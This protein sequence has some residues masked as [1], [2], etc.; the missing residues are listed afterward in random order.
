MHSRLRI[1]RTLLIL[2]LGIAA[3]GRT[4]A[5][6]APHLVAPPA[7]DPRHQT[8]RYRVAGVSTREQRSAIVATGAAIESVGPSEVIVVATPEQAH[9][10]AALGL[11]LEPSPRPSD[12]PIVDAAYHTY[13]EMVADIQAVAAAHPAIVRLFSIGQSYEG[14]ELWAAK[15]SANVDRDEDEPEALF[16]GLYHAREHLT[17]EMLLY[18]LHLLAD[19]YGLAGQEQITDLVDTREIYLIFEL[20]PDGGEY[21]IA[22]GTYRYWRKN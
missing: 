13:A 8:Q 7:P 10:V 17:V 18:I 1:A 19:N 2:L 20:N 11:S 14:R 6:A 15:V 4:P 5:R 12:F 3:V 22:D 9:L 21:D 16:V